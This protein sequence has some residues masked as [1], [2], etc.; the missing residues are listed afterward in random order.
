MGRVILPFPKR[1]GN[2]RAG[3]GLA[4][5]ARE[6]KGMTMQRTLS[7]AWTLFEKIIVPVI[8]I[9]G[10][11]L[12]TASMY[13]GKGGTP[14]GPEMKW[15]FLGILLV[16]SAFIYWFCARLKQVRIDDEALYISNYLKEVR[17]PLR[18]IAEVSENRWVNIHPVTIEFQRDTEFGRSVVFMPKMRW[19]GGWSSHPVVAELREAARR[20]A[21]V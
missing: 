14:P 1:R 18:E 6:S 5:A 13:S 4:C 8:S 9:V 7:S 15:M 17:V 21:G 20:A 19:F 16:G 11:G 12:G 10:F 3:R 2:W